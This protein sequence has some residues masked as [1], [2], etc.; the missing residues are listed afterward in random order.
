MSDLLNEQPHFQDD[1]AAQADATIGA[2]G[3]QQPDAAGVGRAQ[4]SEPERSEGERSGARPTPADS[5]SF[6]PGVG[7]P[8]E[9]GGDLP[10]EEWSRTDDA[11]P[12]LRL[13]GRSKGRRL[14]KQELPPAPALTA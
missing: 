8:G 14:V 13:T 11:G 9:E 2:H 3:E 4:R 6:A 1:R 7:L 12:R 10:L 5:P